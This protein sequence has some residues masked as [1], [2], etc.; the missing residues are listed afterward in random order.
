MA[1][2]KGTP[3]D[4][5]RFI[6]ETV[7]SRGE[8]TDKEIEKESERRDLFGKAFSTSKQILKDDAAFFNQYGL[9]IL[10]PPNE[11]RFSQG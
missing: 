5:R 1:K 8:V 7:N 4:R 6:I 9:D 3:A 10:R 11:G 2:L